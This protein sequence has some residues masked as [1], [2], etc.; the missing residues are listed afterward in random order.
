VPIGPVRESTTRI[1]E[2]SYECGSAGIASSW[3]ELEP[4]GVIGPHWIGQGYW[5]LVLPQRQLLLIGPDRYAFEYFWSWEDWFWRRRP[6]LEQS[7][8]EAW[9][10]GRPQPAVPIHTN[11]YLFSALGTPAALN[12]LVWD[13]STILLISSGTVLLIGLALL[14]APR[15]RHPANL[16]VLAVLITAGALWRLDAAVVLAQAA[17][18]GMLLVLMG[19]LLKLLLSGRATAR[20]IVRPGPS[21]IVDRGSSR[22]QLHQPPGVGSGSSTQAATQLELAQE[23]QH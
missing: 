10:G 1:V 7:D 16:L 8:L 13:R 3:L 20:S 22:T 9:S 17:F 23:S 11:R 14:Q 19:A 12:A 18:V 2:L 15:A 21:S 6:L 5:Q 4:V